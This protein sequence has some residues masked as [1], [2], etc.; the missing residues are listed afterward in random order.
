MDSHL[1]AI[2]VLAVALGASSVSLYLTQ[3]IRDEA[4]FRKTLARS[5]RVWVA[6]IPT[7]A[8]MLTSVMQAVSA[9]TGFPFMLDPSSGFAARNAYGIWM[10]FQYLSLM[11]SSLAFFSIVGVPLVLWWLTQRKPERPRGNAD[12][13][14]TAHDAPTTESSP[15]R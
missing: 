4:Y 12:L 13:S 9:V 5:R 8:L 10:L 6:H 11:L 1:T 3:R 7:M 2:I 14:D 15:H